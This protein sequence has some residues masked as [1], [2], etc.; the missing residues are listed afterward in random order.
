MVFGNMGD[1]S[2]TGVCFTRN[3]SN[4]ERK[5]YGEYLINAQ[6]GGAGTFDNLVPLKSGRMQKWEVI[7]EGSG[8]IQWFIIQSRKAL[9]NPFWSLGPWNVSQ[10][11]GSKASTWESFDAWMLRNDPRNVGDGL[12]TGEHH[13]HPKEKQ[14]STKLRPNNCER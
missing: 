13:R 2:G 14:R 11:F 1:S 6:A 9:G 4:G 5:L 3:P 8:S 7:L 12:K 10:F